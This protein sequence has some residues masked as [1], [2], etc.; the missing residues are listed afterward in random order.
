MNG[1]EKD[2]SERAGSLMSIWTDAPCGPILSVF[3]KLA[4]DPIDR[5]IYIFSDRHRGIYI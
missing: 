1:T 5:G 4:M 2:E 3:I